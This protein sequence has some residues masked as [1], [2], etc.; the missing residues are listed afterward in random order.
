MKTEIENITY[1][2][3]YEKIKDNYDEDM[4]IKI[5]EAYDYANKAH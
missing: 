2:I 4:L 5:K 1:D 3:L